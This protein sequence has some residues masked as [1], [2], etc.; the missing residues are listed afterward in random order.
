M[1]VGTSEQCFVSSSLH[2]VLKLP[3]PRPFFLSSLA[4]TLL[5]VAHHTYRIPSAQGMR[6]PKGYLQDTFSGGHTRPQGIPTGYLPQQDSETTT[7]IFIVTR[8]FSSYLQDTFCNRIP[9]HPT[10]RLHPFPVVTLSPLP[11]GR[12]DEGAWTW[13]LQNNAS[14][15]RHYTSF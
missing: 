12:E 13:E 10:E 2:I 14:F 6:V 7:T 15:L 1:D 5:G 4:N 9:R 11:R 3:R 8:R